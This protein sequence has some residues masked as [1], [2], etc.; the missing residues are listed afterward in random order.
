MRIVTF[1]T[2]LAPTMPDRY[3]RLQDITK[4]IVRWCQSG[5]DIIALQEVPTSTQ[6]PLGLAASYLPFG[7]PSCLSGIFDIAHLTEGSMLPVC[8]DMRIID[9]ISDAIKTHCP[10]YRTY[11]SNVN[12]HG[13]NAGLVTI[14]KHQ[15]LSQCDL[16]FPSDAVHT[17]GAS[18]FTL[19]ANGRYLT[20]ANVHMVPILT[21]T[22]AIYKC[23]RAINFLCQRD[24]YES[25]QRRALCLLSKKI[26]GS[27]NCI[28]AG[29]MNINRLTS[30]AMYNYMLRTLDLP[31]S[32]PRNINTFH[33]LG[34]H[35]MAN[36]EPPGQIDY[37]LGD[38]HNCA[39]DTST[40][41]LSDH[42]PLIA[43]RR[44]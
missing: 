5:I 2:Q 10:G 30:P 6:G 27:N 16:Q 32:S 42:Y 28:V 29:D 22:R 17:R 1:N 19:M 33:K 11:P 13:L 44:T 43:S 38:I 20:F 12:Q 18:V 41:K 36:G 4:Q 15:V 34:S 26:A 25:L 37:I 23:V 7:A 14:T 9:A 8:K 31:D 39:S 35:E 3:E 40:Y 24:D 21:K